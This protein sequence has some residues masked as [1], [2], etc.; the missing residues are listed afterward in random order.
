MTAFARSVA[1]LNA[2]VERRLSNAQATWNGGT[3][4]GVMF[5][6]EQDEGFM[7]DAVTAVRHTVSM[8]VANAP[9]IAEGSAGLVVDGLAYLVIGPVVPD[10]GGW[11]TFAVMPAGGA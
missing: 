4:F 11:A 3:P 8:C 9:G 2:S 7:E 6:R 1:R 5:D 10:S